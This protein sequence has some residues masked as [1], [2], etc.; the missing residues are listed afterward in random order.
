MLCEESQTEGLMIPFK[1]LPDENHAPPIADPH[2][3]P[4]V[5]PTS[6]REPN[7]W[8]Y[9]LACVPFAFII[10]MILMPLSRQGVAMAD[11]ASWV[12]G[13]ILVR[14]LIGLIWQPRHRDWRIYLAALFMCMPLIWGLYIL[15]ALARNVGLL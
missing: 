6:Q 13:A 5:A 4:P 12:D 9:V 1:A 3:A 15:W 8:W 11:A 10:Q 7:G 2:S 14:S